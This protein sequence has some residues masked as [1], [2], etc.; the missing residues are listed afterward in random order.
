[1]SIPN[2]FTGTPVFVGDDV[3]FFETNYRNMARGTVTKIGSAKFTVEYK[4][5]GGPG[6]SKTYRFFADCV[7]IPKLPA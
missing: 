5:K 3:A 1:M 7:K 4:N 2:D 6:T